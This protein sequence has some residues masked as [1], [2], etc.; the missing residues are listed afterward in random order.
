MDAV[1]SSNFADDREQAVDAVWV[2][3]VFFAI[4][5]SYSL[6][7]CLGEPAQKNARR[8][9]NADGSLVHLLGALGF[10]IQ[11]AITTAGDRL[12]CSLEAQDRCPDVPKD[13][14]DD[15]LPDTC[16]VV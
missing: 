11:A 16:D 14:V 8:H 15:V 10:R 6:E 13:S 3:N 9:G 2:K 12:G 4:G 1:N 7:L 5:C